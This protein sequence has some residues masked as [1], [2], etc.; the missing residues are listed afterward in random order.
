MLFYK[1]SF[2]LNFQD[3]GT[4]QL[5]RYA[6]WYSGTWKNLTETGG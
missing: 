1:E 5:E 4:I 6:A 3:G 2:S